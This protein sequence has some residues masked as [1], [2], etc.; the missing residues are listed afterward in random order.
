MNEIKE[1]SNSISKLSAEEINAFL[2]EI[3]TENEISTLSNRWRILKMLNQNFSQRDISSKLN[4]SLC[5]ITRGAKILKN[6]NAISLR[7]IK[8]IENEYNKITR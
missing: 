6:K 1:I 3:L 7:L 2:A 8:E 4:V 5:K